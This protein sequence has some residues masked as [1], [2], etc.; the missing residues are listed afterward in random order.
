LAAGGCFT[1][2]GQAK[3]PVG[4]GENAAGPN[5]YAGLLSCLCTIDRTLRVISFGFVTIFRFARKLLFSW[6]FIHVNKK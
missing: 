2:A 1:H 3:A 4:R 6:F 5:V